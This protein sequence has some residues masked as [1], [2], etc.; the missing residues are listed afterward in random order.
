MSD[1]RLL[2]SVTTFLKN[3]AVE[4]TIQQAI[5]GDLGPLTTLH[6]LD[7]GDG[8]AEEVFHK[9]KQQPLPFEFFYDSQN[10]SPIWDSKNGSIQYFL[11]KGS[12]PFLILA[13]DDNIYRKFS[14]PWGKETV[15]EALLE[16]HQ[17]TQFPHIMCYLDDLTPP[18]V[19]HDLF[20]RFP[21]V[22]A[23]PWTVTC[24]GGTMGSY[25]F[26]TRLAVEV[27][28]YFNR[29]P[30][31]YGGEHAEYSARINKLAGWNPEFFILLDNCHRYI[32]VLGEANNY[33]VSEAEMEENMKVYRKRIGEIYNGKDLSTLRRPTR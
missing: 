25:M 18:S 15:N 11:E 24:H 23:T 4:N 3:K 22:S 19:T 14:F 26:Y 13:D 20:K 9:Y 6:I 7:A 12:W 10:M 5:A 2:V 16:A 30:A 28:G 31:R 1:T 33:T 27:T 29:F 21:P 32:S 17:K 8:H